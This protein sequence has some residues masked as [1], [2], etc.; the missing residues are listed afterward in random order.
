MN[1]VNQ[2]P[3]TN[4]SNE[5]G[6]ADWLQALMA[7][8]RDE[9]KDVV[10]GLLTDKEVRLTTLPNSGLGL[11]KFNDSALNQS[12]YLGEFPLASASVEITLADGSQILGAAQVMDDDSDFA[13]SLAIADA[14][15][16]HGA[17]DSKKLTEMVAQGQKKRQDE[18]AIRQSILTRTKVD[19]SLL[20]M[21]DDRDTGEIEDE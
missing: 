6:R 5:T 11:L 1:E 2:T 15:L 19:F 3:N 14:I 10:Q 21:A 4:R 16:A 9:V 17:E 7:L 20:N 18:Q 12:F 13:T 8:S